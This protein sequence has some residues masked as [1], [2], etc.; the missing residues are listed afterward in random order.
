M[1]S[2]RG[3]VT[4]EEVERAIKDGVRY[5]KTQQRE[6]GSWADLDTSARTG[7]TSLVT[8]ALLTA[9]EPADSPHVARALAFLSEFTPDQLRSVYAVS[10]QTMVFAAAE[11]DRDQLRINLNVAWLQRAQIKRGEHV[12]WPGSWSYTAEK[13]RPG[14]N[15]NTQYALLGLNAAS[16]VG[17]PIEPQVW[18]LARQYWEHAQ[19]GDGSWAYTPDSNRASTASMTCAGI[20]SLVITGLKR[21]Q[22]QEIL[23]GETIQNCGKGGVNLNLQRAIDWMAAN[24]RVG[25]NYGDGQNWKYYYLYGLERA[26]RLTGQRFFGNHDWYRE[27]AEELVHA[28][29]KLGGYWRGIL[30]EGQDPLVATSFALLF[31]AKGRAPVLINKLRH[32]PGAT[33]TSTPTTSATSSGP[34]PGTGRTS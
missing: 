16:E 33:G 25:Q 15:S 19:R 12:N 27:G 29:E 5:L 26:G 22:G 34:S 14:D 30:F 4:R 18:N 24:F 21:Y 17:V 9:G 6:D 13:G 3:A 11:P 8:L 32:G 28:Q 10:L 2:A 20:S 7:S 23:A 31:L 1:S